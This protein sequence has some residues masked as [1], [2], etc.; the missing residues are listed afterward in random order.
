M[1]HR[2]PNAELIASSCGARNSGVI[3]VTMAGAG[4]EKPGAGS[5]FVAGFG[6]SGTG[7]KTDLGSPCG[8]GGEG[9][10][11]TA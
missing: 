11:S 1:A 6:R 5:V 4:L 3:L 8:L 2:G 10:R 7:G 9:A